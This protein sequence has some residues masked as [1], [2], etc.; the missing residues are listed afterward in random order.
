VPGGG[1]NHPRRAL[2]RP[3][4]R[5]S[6][7]TRFRMKPSS[8]RRRLLRL[9]L[10]LFVLAA[11]AAPA[12]AFAAN[13]DRHVV[14]ISIDGFPAYLWR[15][16]TLALPHLR[17][18]A[19]EGVVADALT[20]VNPAITWP[21]HTSLV[22]GVE[23]RKHGVLY[24]GLVTRQGPGKPIKNEQ[25]ADKKL[26]VRVP[27]VY[28]AAFHAGLTTAEV[29]WV[30]ITRPGTINWSF[31][32]I[33]DP[34]AVLPREMVAAGIATEKEILAVAEKKPVTGTNVEPPKRLNAAERDELWTRAASFVFTQHRPNLLLFH[35]LNTDGQHHRYGPY[36]P[37][38][39]AALRLADR[40]V[41]DLL[42]AIDASGLREKTTVIVTTDHGF[43][44]VQSYI[45]P[46][47]ALK[48][49]GLLRSAG[50]SIAQCD[51]YVGTQGGIA[52]VYVTDPARRAELLPRLK[53]LFAGV[54]G[55]DRVLDAAT[56]AH[57]LGMPTPAEN[58]AMGELI[59]Y[60]KAGYAFTAAAAGEVV[61][62]PAINYGG[63]H[64]YPNTDPELDG[65]F[66]AQGAGIRRGVKLNRVRNLDVAPTIARLLDVALPTADGK[67]MADVLAPR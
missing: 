11:A 41:G 65:I 37:E 13:K 49:A 5:V 7:V 33:V 43:K 23:P 21:N 15:D 9:A 6:L 22:T 18:L 26:L 59:L 8:L 17:K 60:P 44:K 45:Y 36:S 66:I 64:G 63:T 10:P 53:T 39:L 50:P 40:Y 16:E 48:K 52:F 42:K 27:T 57:A 58:E 3:G 29:D 51:A 61:N 30:A 35:P 19:A 67:P 34:T 25:W 4:A 24:N 31:A 32:E 14:L 2:L 56:E 38:G 1:K 47:V 12:D 28:D 20:I 55:V 54:E 46:N 62:G